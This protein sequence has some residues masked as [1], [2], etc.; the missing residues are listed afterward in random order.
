M[1]VHCAIYFA[2]HVSFKVWGNRAYLK[3][4]WVSCAVYLFGSLV[5]R[6]VYPLGNWHYNP[7]VPTNACVRLHS[8][9]EGRVE[10][11]P[12]SIK[13]YLMVEAIGASHHV[14]FWNVSISQFLWRKAVKTLTTRTA[15]KIKKTNPRG[16]QLN[17]G[18]HILAATFTNTH[19][20]RLNATKHLAMYTSR[21]SSPCRAHLI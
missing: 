19:T 2:T 12:L 20:F 3:V 4:Q 8:L 1:C 17:G 9:L 13:K 14:L 7:D 21:R 6:N 18:W 16:R 11:A 15:K 5:G 10:F